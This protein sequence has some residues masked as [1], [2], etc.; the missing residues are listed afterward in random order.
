MKALLVKM[1]TELPI[2]QP[3]LR[4]CIQQR[5]LNQEFTLPRGRPPLNTSIPCEALCQLRRGV[6]LDAVQFGLLLFLDVFHRAN[7]GPIYDPCQG[8]GRKIVWA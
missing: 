5:L 3:L 1:L 7:Y 2:N 4:L 8:L 6:D